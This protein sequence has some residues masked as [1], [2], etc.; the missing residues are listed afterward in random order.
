MIQFTH[1]IRT[2]HSKSSLKK[3]RG[4][5]FKHN[6]TICS[7]GKKRPHKHD[8]I[9]VNQNRPVGIKKKKD[10][11][12][13]SRANSAHISTP[14]G[15]HKSVSLDLFQSDLLINVVE[16]GSQP[17][18]AGQGIVELVAFLHHVPIHLLEVNGRCVLCRSGKKEGKKN[19]RQIRET[20]RRQMN[21]AGTVGKA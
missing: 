2:T 9:S 18:R 15:G 1:T 14:R 11:R 17:A 7:T 8:V 10:G 6:E 16:L 3:A 4:V 12:V 21:G 19:G 5:F 20:E 13:K